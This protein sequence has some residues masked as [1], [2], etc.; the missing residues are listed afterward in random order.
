MTHNKLPP[1]DNEALSRGYDWTA[2]AYLPNMLTPAYRPADLYGQHSTPR[3]ILDD[4]DG[5]A[6]SPS[7]MMGRASVINLDADDEV[8]D[9]ILHSDSEDSYKQKGKT[10]RARSTASGKSSGS[11]KSD[12]SGEKS[13]KSSAHSISQIKMRNKVSP[14]GYR[15][16]SAIST[17]DT[18]SA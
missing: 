17:L 3:L 6:D 13:R 18:T 8:F 15:R 12:T 14:D 7:S 16:P 2:P 10:S 11:G 9:D 5:E 1:V 4:S